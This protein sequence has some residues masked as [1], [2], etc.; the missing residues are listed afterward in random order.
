MITCVVFEWSVRIPLDE[1]ENGGLLRRRVNVTTPAACHSYSNPSAWYS[2]CDN[3]NHHGCL[4]RL[5]NADS[6]LLL[7]PVHTLGSLSEDVAN[8][9]FPQIEAFRGTNFQYGCHIASS[10]GL[11]YHR[12]VVLQLHNLWVMLLRFAV[13]GRRYCCAAIFGRTELETVNNRQRSYHLAAI[14]TF[15]ARLLG[16]D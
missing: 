3:G 10:Y 9:T 13:I 5:L 16:A 4:G 12:D 8:S 1:T 14:S 7:P 6:R 15:E 2:Q 11:V